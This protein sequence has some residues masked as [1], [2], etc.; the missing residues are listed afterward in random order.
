MN[1]LAISDACGG[2]GSIIGLVK[3]ILG[4]AFIL[5]GVVLVVLIIIDIAKAIIASEEKEVKGYQKAAIRRVI[6]FVVMFFVVTLVTVITNLVGGSI[7]NPSDATNWA[8]CWSSP[9]DACST[10]PETTDD[11]G[12]P[13]C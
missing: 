7:D 10:T 12:L 8:K 11:N 6:Y 1:F 13:T 9:K 2:L 5:I 3:Q 4:Y